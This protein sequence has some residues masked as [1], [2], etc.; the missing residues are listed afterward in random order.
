VAF[1]PDGRRLASA[2]HDGTV[3][4]DATTGQEALT[5]RGHARLVSSVAFSP[6]GRRLASAGADGT[7]KL[8][9]ATT[10]QETVTLRGHAGPVE[11]VAFSPDGQRLA[12]A[13]EDGTMKVWDATTGQEALSLRGH[14][15]GVKSVAFSPDGRRLASAGWDRT[16]KLWDATT[17]QEVLTLRGHAR[18]VRSVVFSPDGLRLASA[19]EDATVKIWDSTPMTPESLARD[20]PLRLIR[21]LLERVASEAELLDRIVGDQTISEETR[22]TAL[23]LARGFWATWIRGRADRLVSSLF[24][25]LVLRADV[26]DSLRADPTLDPEL[27]A[28]ALALAETW[29]EAA[30]DLNNAAWMLDKAAWM[31][32]KL[33]NTNRREADL[34]RGLRLAE[35]ACQLEPENGAY[36][37]TLGV[38]QYRMGQYEKAQATLKRSNELRGNRDP[39]DLAFLAMTQHRLNRVEEARAT[40]ERFREV[41]QDPKVA[42]VEENL[43]FLREAESVILNAPDLPADVFARWD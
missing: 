18:P 9:D 31:L 41:M 30:L 39:T 15:G 21:F 36:L 8:W 4:W 12:S 1:S 33:P 25:R 10:G 11:S 3:V 2:G 7:V 29:P 20:D 17:G 32:V 35:R 38:A 23:K 40:L 34:R 42:A 14:S 16:V 27:R 26:L 5:L 22:A 43:E 6:D 19:S 37:K 13:G 24:D 28:A